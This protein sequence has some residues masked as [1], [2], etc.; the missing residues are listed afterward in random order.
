M[1]DLLLK[2]LYKSFVL[3]QFYSNYLL[4]KTQSTQSNLMSEN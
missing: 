2:Y 1:S 3:V 4:T